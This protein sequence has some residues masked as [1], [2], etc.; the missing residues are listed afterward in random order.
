[1]LIHTPVFHVFKEN[2]KSTK[3]FGTNAVLAYGR[4]C[5]TIFS[6]N[7]YKYLDK[8]GCIDE[9]MEYKNS[10]KC[11]VIIENFPIL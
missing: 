8:T 10:E 6:S 3:R 1:M 9:G 7:V 4:T 5:K 11:S 2:D